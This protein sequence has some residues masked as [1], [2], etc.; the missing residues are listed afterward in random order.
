M[1]IPTLCVHVVDHCNFHCEGCSHFSPSFR[2]KFYDAGD[3][4]PAMAK[5]AGWCEVGMIRI[6]GGEPF[7]H[8]DIAEFVRSIHGSPLTKRI[9]LLTN[10]SWM[11]EERI[12]RMADVWPLVSLFHLSLHPELKIN[13]SEA[14]RLATTIGG[15]GCPIEISESETFDLPTFT[16]TPNGR[17]SCPIADCMQLTA[18]GSLVRC[19][20]IAY[21]TPLAAREAFNRS[22]GKFDIWNGTREGFE[23]FAKGLPAC[24][25]FCAFGHHTGKKVD[26]QLVQLK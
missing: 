6:A 25:Q 3:Y 1:K 10:G 12:R 19:P 4:L 24:C 23:S 22:R 8:K 20:V 9:E 18:D 11:S 14:R 15:Y 5:L 17:R 21:A 13:Y 7:L 16:E 26:H 2:Q